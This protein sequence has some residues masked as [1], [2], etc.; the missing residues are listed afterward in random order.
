VP[1]FLADIAVL[2]DDPLTAKPEALQKLESALTM[3]GGRVAHGAG[4]A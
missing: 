4:A 2:E 3:V 1:G